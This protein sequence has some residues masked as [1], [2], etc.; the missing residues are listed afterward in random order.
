MLIRPAVLSLLFIALGC[1]SPPHTTVDAGSVA[2]EVNAP[3]QFISGRTPQ[4]QT[5]TEGQALALTMAAIDADGDAVTYGARWEDPQPPASLLFLDDALDPV[6][7]EFAW[8]PGF[9]DQRTEP[10]RASFWASDVHG[11]TTAIAVRITVTNTNRVPVVTVGE[12]AVVGDELCSSVSNPLSCAVVEGARLTLAMQIATDGED[13]IAD[14]SVDPAP[15]GSSL[16]AAPGRLGATFTW[17]PGHTEPVAVPIVLTFR[18][19]DSSGAVGEATVQVTIANLNRAPL[20]VAGGTPVDRSVAEDEL[21][22]FTLDATDADGDAVTFGAEWNDPAPP[23]SLGVLAAALDPDSGAFA[24]TPGHEDHRSAPYVAR[25]WAIDAR[26]ASS[27]ATVRVTVTDSNRTPVVTV[28]E[29]ASVGSEHCVLSAG[30]LR[31]AV[32]EGTELALAVFAA[33]D[34]DDS[35][36]AIEVDAAPAGSSFV[37]TADRRSAVFRWVAGFAAAGASPVTLGFS[38]TDDWGASATTLVE[39]TIN[40]VNRPPSMAIREVPSAIARCSDTSPAI[41]QVPEDAMTSLVVSVTD[42]ADETVAG[43][44]MVAPDEVAAASTFSAATDGRSGTLTFSPGYAD[45]RPGAYVFRFVATDAKGATASVYAFVTVVDVNRTPQLLITETGGGTDRCTSALGTAVDPIVCVIPEDYPLELQLA[46]TDPDA[47]DFIRSL[48]MSGN[49]AG[50]ELLVDA[51]HAAGTFAWRPTFAQAAGPYA[52]VFTARDGQGAA[53][54]KFVRLQATDVNRPPQLTLT[55]GTVGAANVCSTQPTACYVDYAVG[56][57]PTLVLAFAASDP[58]GDSVMLE[59]SPGTLPSANTLFD[60]VSGILLFTPDSPT[61]AT[62]T[63]A[64]RARDSFATETALSFEVHVNAINVAPT[65]TLLGCPDRVQVG[66]ALGCSMLVDDPDPRDRPLVLQMTALAGG[67]LAYDA[68]T[69][70]GRF[71]YAAASSGSYQVTFA[72]TDSHG[73]M[74]AVPYSFDVT[75]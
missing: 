2:P 66:T 57:V 17:V 43:L 38:A 64:V 24:W 29:T 7:G 54:T 72:A 63:A 67:G 56:P 30:E 44:T 9:G 39:V 22:A 70:F 3:P 40:D 74:T 49:P 6:S 21:L 27:A 4:D 50:A 68:T 52:I 42:D 51:T 46:A 11:A 10:Y 16:Q 73:A 47:S 5:I 19:T 26:G 35:I 71:L 75:N 41:C 34:S 58:D 12:V 33:D 28:A 62:Y 18:A 61:P 69:G 13:D 32:D 20:F 55:F 1:G 31:C 15:T 36:A 65:I 14:I 45:G 25:F 48:E 23:T 60:A 8:T 59:L 37:A 53:A